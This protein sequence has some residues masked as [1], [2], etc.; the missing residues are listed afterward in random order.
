[1]PVSSFITRMRSHLPPRRFNCAVAVLTLG[2]LSATGCEK[3]KRA[4]KGDL[5]GD[6][7]WQGDST[8]LASKP[9]LLFRVVRQNGTERVWPLATVGKQGFRGLGFSNRGWRAFDLAYFQQGSSLTAYQNG[10]PQATVKTSRGMWESGKP[11]LDS[12]PGC[13]VLM[14]SAEAP[15]GDGIW[16][17]A[18]S[19]RTPLK[20]V[21]PM[22]SGEL[23]AA[24]EAVP[25][26]IA[27]TSGISGSMMSRYTRQVHVVAAGTSTSPSIIVIYNDP[28]GLPDSVDAYGERPRQLVVVLDKGVYGYRPTYTYTTVANNKTPPRLY[29]LDYFD[30]DDDGKAELFFGVND[31]RAPAYTLVLRFENEAW[32]ENQRL[33]VQVCQG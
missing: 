22:S 3:V 1:M 24:L 15:V 26:L 31:K 6:P 27:P 12:M 25:T 18:S 16:L 17:L 7:Q 30:V 2:M 32:R 20:P 29:F 9:P 8:V 28:A 14:P 10:R 21:D 23:A 5:G 19:P 11:A 4:L 33:L 13:N